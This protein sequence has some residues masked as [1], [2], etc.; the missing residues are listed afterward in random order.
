MNDIKGQI[1]LYML[2]ILPR[3][4]QIFLGTS[5]PSPSLSGVLASQYLNFTPT[6]L[7][8]W[9]VPPPPA[10]CHPPKTLPTLS[11]VSS[12]YLPFISSAPPKSE[13]YMYKGVWYK[14]MFKAPV[15]HSSHTV[16]TAPI[17]PTEFSPSTPSAVTQSDTSS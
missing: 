15:C 1:P 14:P 13:T 3:S 9:N 16:G 2:P 12:T 4:S 5:L 6:C 11:Y 10:A 17:P 7:Y 8:T